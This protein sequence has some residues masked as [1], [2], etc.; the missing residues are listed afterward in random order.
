MTK[1]GF[2]P[3]IKQYGWFLQVYGR[4]IVEAHY[5]ACLYA[6][7]RISGTNAEVRQNWH[8][9]T[10]SEMRVAPQTA[11]NAS[12]YAGLGL[13]RWTFEGSSSESTSLLISVN[14][15]GDAVS[16]GI[17][18]WA[19]RG[20]WH[21]RRPL[22]GQVSLNTIIHPK[23]NQIISHGWHSILTSRYILQR[24]GEDFGVV[25]TFDPKVKPALNICAVTHKETM[26]I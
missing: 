6:G 11:T 4:D 8:Q 5:R 10:A 2:L 20:D 1:Y 7:I 26:R 9:I 14:K 12:V 16:M 13:D 21:G 22:G 15:L 23:S 24:V 19:D 18:S 25:V 3:L 17:P